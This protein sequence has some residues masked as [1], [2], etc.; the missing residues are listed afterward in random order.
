MSIIRTGSAH[1]S[2]RAFLEHPCSLPRHPNAI[3]FDAVIFCPED[4]QIS[5]RINCSLC[6]LKHCPKQNVPA[7]L[8]DI[9]AKVI[10][11][12]TMKTLTLHYR[13]RL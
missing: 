12:I 4:V 1:L 6:Y 13:L 3:F 9:F 11:T 10:D 7:G 8:Y 5:G 2:C